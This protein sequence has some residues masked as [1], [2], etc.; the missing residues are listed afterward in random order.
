MYMHI[1]ILLIIFCF[2][3]KHCNITNAIL[4]SHCDVI[5]SFICFLILYYVF[6]IY[7]FSVFNFWRE[8]CWQCVYLRLFIILA[9]RGVT[10]MY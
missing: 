10:I 8:Y 6:C 2:S 1:V 3:Y 4:F 7:I 9:T 5:A